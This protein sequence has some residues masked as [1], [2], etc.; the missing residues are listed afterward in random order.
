MFALGLRCT[1]CSHELDA[2]PYFLGCTQCGGALEVFYDED[3]IGK[4]VSLEEWAHRTPSVWRYRE[5]LP[6]PADGDPVTL[7]EGAAPMVEAPAGLENPLDMLYLQN[8]TVN[9]TFSFK[10]RF[11]TVSVSMARHFGIEK[12]VCSTTGNHGMSAA[13]YAARAGMD[14]VIL[15]DPRT[16]VVQ[17][18]WMRLFGATVVVEMERQPPL[19]AFVEQHGWYPSTYMTPMPVSTPYGVEGYKTMAYDAVLALGRAP[20]HFVF[21]VAAGDGLYGPWKG[22]S[23]LYRL[24]LVDSVPKIHGVQPAGANPI[25]QAISEGLD[26]VPVHPNPESLALSIADATGGRVVLDAIR[27]S[28]GT[29]VEVSDEQIIAAM[30]YA[31]GIGLSAE[32]SSAAS[33]AGAWELNRQGAIA[34]G[35]SVVCAITGAG[36]KWPDVV[37]AFVPGEELAGIGAAEYRDLASGTRPTRE[38]VFP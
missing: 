8:E 3:A 37:S 34:S 11:H 20:D 4:L 14:C 27:G 5:L 21:P 6:L 17:R 2:G 28:G 22:Y 1:E 32:P 25:V 19:Q 10:D 9:P 12:V 29:A 24:G 30:Y 13:A 16:P 38:E 15:V 35:E 26:F 18:D 36:P 7:G 33:I 23:E 31:A